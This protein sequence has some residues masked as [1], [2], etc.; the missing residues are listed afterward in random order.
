M[1]AH[2]CGCGKPLTHLDSEPDSPDWPCR[3]EL[4]SV[5]YD[6]AVKSLTDY[7]DSL[8]HSL[9]AEELT[10]FAE[11]LADKARQVEFIAWDATTAQER[12]QDER[13]DAGLEW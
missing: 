13:E 1:T 5:A 11:E 12:A 10:L 3:V 4:R 8:I 6:Q 7:I 9:T 2:M